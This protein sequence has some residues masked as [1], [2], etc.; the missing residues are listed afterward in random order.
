MSIADAPRDQA[1]HA[2]AGALSQP[3]GDHPAQVCQH[4]HGILQRPDCR[5][6]TVHACHGHLTDLVPVD[7]GAMKELDIEAEPPGPEPAKEVSG[8][9]PP[10]ALEAALRVLDAAEE[11]EPHEQV[12]RLDRKSTRLNS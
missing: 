5:S 9:V 4:G 2:E 6:T 12:Q 1:G 10:K 7:L 3:P 8:H 11:E